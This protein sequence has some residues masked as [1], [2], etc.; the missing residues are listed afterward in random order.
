MTRYK[1][2]KMTWKHPESQ[3]PGPGWGPEECRKGNRMGGKGETAAD[4][5]RETRKVDKAS[6][7]K[8]KHI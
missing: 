7:S 4:N 3:T 2:R 1:G 8:A 5:R 6:D